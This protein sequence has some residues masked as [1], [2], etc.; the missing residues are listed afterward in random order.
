MQRKDVFA[1]LPTRFGKSVIFGI[2]PTAFDIYLD[3][4]C[5]S[6]AVVIIPLIALMKEFKDRFVPRGISAE[7]VGEL[8]TDTEATQNY[9]AYFVI[10]FS[11][12]RAF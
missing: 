11:K 4:P 10:L 8:Q 5:T 12:R 2:L 1:A 3:R 9:L 7:F 6:I